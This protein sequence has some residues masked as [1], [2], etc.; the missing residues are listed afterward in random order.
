MLQVE[1]GDN[2]L[3]T[4]RGAA[5]NFVTTLVAREAIRVIGDGYSGVIPNALPE[6]LARWGLDVDLDDASLN[7]ELDH[8]WSHRQTSLGPVPLQWN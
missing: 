8:I 2:P 5:L 1:P 6:V 4:A 3:L 7:R